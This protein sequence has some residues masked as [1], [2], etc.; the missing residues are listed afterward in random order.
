MTLDAGLLHL[1]PDSV[2]HE[3]GI[4]GQVTS[5]LQCQ[6]SPL[7]AGGDT[8]AHPIVEAGSCGG[9]TAVRFLGRLVESEPL[10]PASLLGLR[11]NETE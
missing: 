2:P 4:L 6:L 11:G 5:F 10:S 1:H 3:L 7:P 9:V 8:W